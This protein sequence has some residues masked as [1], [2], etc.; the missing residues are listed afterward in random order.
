MERQRG[1][2]P[3]NVYTKRDLNPPPRTHTALCLQSNGLEAIVSNEFNE[4]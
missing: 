3:Q 4:L 1:G 2:A